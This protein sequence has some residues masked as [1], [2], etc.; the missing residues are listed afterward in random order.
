[1]SKK[2][3][4]AKKK[5]VTFELVNRSYEDPLNADP[6]APTHV[7]VPIHKTSNVTDEDVERLAKMMAPEKKEAPPP[8]FSNGIGSQFN[9]YFV[10]D[11]DEDD[12]TDYSK[13]FKH[14]DEYEDDG[15]FIAPDGTVHDL[16]KREVDN[17]DVLAGRH[18]F[19]A[20][21]FGTDIDPNMPK[22]IDDTDN[23]LASG[24]DMDVLLAMDDEDVDELDDD[25]VSKALALE[26]VE[27]SDEDED[28][29]PRQVGQKRVTIAKSRVSEAPSHMSRIS[30]RSEAMDIVEERVAF[31]LDTVYNDEEEDP[32][33]EEEEDDGEVDW[34]DIISDFKKF[35]APITNN[36]VAPPPSTDNAEV[37]EEAEK[38]EEEEKEEVEVKKREERWDAESYLETLS[39]TENRPGVVRDDIIPSKNKK[40]KRAQKEE[41]DDEEL[42]PPEMQ[43]KPGETKEEAK[44]RKKAI[45]EYNKMR[46]QKKKELKQKFTCAKARV[47][48]S[49]AAAGSSRGQRIFPLD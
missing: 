34:D 44:A 16:K 20:E 13:F 46:R 43:P 3:G 37:P 35:R 9:K 21:L 39:T 11:I 14:I 45:K 23:P 27:F 29:A 10:D 48:K 12:D 42:L 31:L 47:K 38:E 15:V 2:G 18:G 41:S 26:T 30:H 40:K 32:E 25:F 8:D 22:L 5:V 7:L 17:V 33:F 6:N 49:I 28:E 24:M 4:K 1:M 36:P 19:S